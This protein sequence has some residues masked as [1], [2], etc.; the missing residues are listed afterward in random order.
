[1]VRVHGRNI[2]SAVSER[3]GKFHQ[4]SFE[5][6]EAI[7][8]MVDYEY[9]KTEFAAFGP[10]ILEITDQTPLPP[11]FIPYYKEDGIALM[12][13]K[14]PRDIERR[15]ANQDMDL[16]DYI[17]GLYE[18]HIYILERVD[19]NVKETV[20][21]YAEMEAL[22]NYVDILAGKFTI[23]LHDRKVII[24]YNAVSGEIINRM[25]RII[26]DRYTVK[27]YRRL[28]SPYDCDS[29]KSMI[30]EIRYKNLLAEMRADHE[31]FDVTVIQPSVMLHRMNR[32]IRQRVLQ[33]LYSE[34]LLGS[35]HLASEREILVISR[36]KPFKTRKDVISCHSHSHLYIPIEKLQSVLF[37]KNDCF[38][39]LQKLSMKTNNYT[40]LFYFEDSNKESQDYYRNMISLVIA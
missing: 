9:R 37:E 32:G 40:F 15:K 36:G 8:N 20:I 27:S 31:S 1:V 22:E 19:R 34:R 29:E 18:D 21:S 10:W 35:L 38:D 24:P 6:W 4:H 2:G 33:F 13:I 39:N 11:L 26:R 23:F 3:N 17:I 25:M 12:R 5:V 14:I 16:Y 30:K 7:N 28:A